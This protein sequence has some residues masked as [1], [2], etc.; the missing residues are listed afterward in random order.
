[1]YKVPQYHVY[2]AE[3]VFFP[4]SVLKPGC[5]VTE[6]FEIRFYKRGEDTSF[7]QNIKR[8]GTIMKLRF[9]MVAILVAMAVAFMVP[10]MASAGPKADKYLGDGEMC[11]ETYQIKETRIL[12]DQ[13]I[14]FIMRSGEL[15]L[16]RLPARCV[17]LRIADGFG[18]S[19]RIAKLCKQDRITAASHG[20]MPGNTCMLGEFLSFDKQGMKTTEV[21][22]LL[23]DGLLEEL[24]AEG[25]FQEAF[26]EEK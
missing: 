8:K 4:G 2:R 24:V 25:V 10:G 22:K 26:P 3:Q 1:V 16:N 20:S 12:D 13:T 14:L 7:F 19:T 5:P 6:P 21:I 23:K 9:N 17:G 11:L 18:Y 15:Y